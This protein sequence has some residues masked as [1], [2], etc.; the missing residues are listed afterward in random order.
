MSVAHAE[1]ALG[2][3]A[4]VSARVLDSDLDFMYGD[5]VRALKL[6]PKTKDRF[7]CMLIERRGAVKTLALLDAGPGEA[8]LAER[9]KRIRD[10]ADSYEASMCALLSR[11]QYAVYQDY[12]KTL[13]PRIQFKVFLATLD[14]AAAPLAAKK[15]Q[16]L[17][18]IALT[19]NRP[20]MDDP[21]S[22][23]RMQDR[24]DM[25][26]EITDDMISRMIALQTRIDEAVLTKSAK[27]LT[28]MQLDL[29]RRTLSR[30]R[31]SA[32]SA[33]TMG[34]FFYWHLKQEKKSLRTGVA[35][36]PVAP[37]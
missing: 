2:T 23:S 15:R 7:V 3:E 6:D 22:V 28:P 37:R 19:E 1:T 35:G 4:K 10:R 33:M 25:G 14:E 34:K 20:H 32:K 27:H 5:L 30:H 9:D 31:D 29:Y 12:I 36:M 8:S 11:A 16:T 24:V 21:I 17:L 13:V 18:D 26:Q